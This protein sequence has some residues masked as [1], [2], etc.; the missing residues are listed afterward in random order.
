MYGKVAANQTF[1]NSRR[2]IRGFT[3]IRNW[4]FSK[5]NSDRGLLPPFPFRKEVGTYWYGGLLREN[6][7]GTYV[8]ENSENS[9]GTYGRI[10]V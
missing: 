4:S 5:A 3:L 6:S 2:S 7:E 9:E 8:Q 10:R 1:E